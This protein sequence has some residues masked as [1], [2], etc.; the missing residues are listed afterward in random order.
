MSDPSLPSKRSHE[1]STTDC[2]MECDG[3]LSQSYTQVSQHAPMCSISNEAEDTAI[4]C[5]ESAPT[6]STLELLNK[7]E[8]K[9]SMNWQHV[10][11]PSYM[12]KDPNRL[13]NL[14]TTLSESLERRGMSNWAIWTQK[15][16]LYVALIYI[17]VGADSCPDFVLWPVQMI[18]LRAHFLPYPRISGPRSTGRRMYSRQ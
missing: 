14:L 10:L 3:Y 17:R 18:W 16:P 8:F 13:I 9:D 4:G 2:H 11:K 6:H 7:A 1:I 5:D 15:L 12:P